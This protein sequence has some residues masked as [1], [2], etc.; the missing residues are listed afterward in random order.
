MVTT[1]LAIPQQDLKKGN[2]ELLVVEGKIEA[3]ELN[4][5]T[6]RDKMQV[7]TA[8]PFLIGKPLNLRDIEQGLDQLNRLSS[9]RAT[10]QIVPGSKDGYSKIVISN[11]PEK[12]NRATIGYDNSGQDSTGKNKGTASLERDNL[13]GL[14]DYWSLNFNQDTSAHG[15]E[16]SSDILS[17]QM[18]VPLG[19]W[20]FSS[21]YS[22]SNYV[23]TIHGTNQSFQTSGETDSAGV[24]LDRVLHRDQDSKTSGNFGLVVKNT[25]NF[26]EDVELATGTQQLTIFKTGVDH[27]LRA[28]DAIWFGAIGYERGIDALG[29][30]SDASSI[31]DSDAHAQFDKFTFDASVY[32]PFAIKSA[33]FAYRTSISGQYSNDTLFSSE[34]LNI[35]DRY[36]V[37]GF[38]QSS[39]AGD[40][41]AYIRNELMWN[42]PQFT[43]NKYVN[44]LVGG[45]QPYIALDGGTVKNHVSDGAD[46]MS[47]WAIGIR[48]NSDWLAFD[49]A[50]SKAIRN[51][52]FVAEES[53]EPYFS[54]TAKV[55]F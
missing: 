42:A 54:V 15:G 39:M 33:S 43:D 36:T 11:A 41:G 19:Y 21:N 22:H 25:T 45:L 13:F 53:Y 50:Y 46:Y 37:R 44:N 30:H 5:N 32:R 3:I 34:K 28:L 2:L 26:L 10:M 8:F 38:Q 7:K 31:A 20:T 52:A 27:T 23:S 51:P 14:G 9:S 17:A 49:V 29:A 4:E 18:S 55:G 40:S 24:K 16:K 1:R 35:G 48:N 12:A 47:G 6:T